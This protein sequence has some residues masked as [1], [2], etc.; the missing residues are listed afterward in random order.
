MILYVIE[1][2]W[3]GEGWFPCATDPFMLDRETAEKK[4]WQLLNLRVGG[5]TNHAVPELRI[6]EYA[7]N[8]PKDDEEPK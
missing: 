3:T 4:L 8:T 5:Q 7:R 1:R 6:A 2:H